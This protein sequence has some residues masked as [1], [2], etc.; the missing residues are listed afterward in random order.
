MACAAAAGSDTGRQ[1][2]GLAGPGQLLEAGWL[3]TSPQGLPPRKDAS[4]FGA[5]ASCCS[6][7]ALATVPHR[8]TALPL[9]HAAGEP[10][11]RGGGHGAG[12]EVSCWGQHRSLGRLPSRGTRPLLR[13]LESSFEASSQLPSEA[14][15][16]PPSEARRQ[17]ATRLTYHV[18]PA[19]HPRPGQVVPRPQPVEVSCMG[20]SHA[21]EAVSLVAGHRWAHSRC[22][23]ESWPCSRGESAAG[24]PARQ[25]GAAACLSRAA[26]PAGRHWWHSSPPRPQPQSAGW[27]WRRPPRSSA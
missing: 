2:W 14:S 27:R 8:V 15:S 11:S 6:A 17:A 1:R 4:E 7:P 23:L 9:S 13:S 3:T 10:G 16:H 20:R 19:E 5:T 12:Q 18:G 21:T 26:L 25:S 22:C 24:N